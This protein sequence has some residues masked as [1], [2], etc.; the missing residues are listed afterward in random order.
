[1]KPRAGIPY[2]DG[3]IFLYIFILVVIIIVIGIALYTALIVQDLQDRIAGQME[4]ITINTPVVT[5]ENPTVCPGDILVWSL[6]LTYH[7]APMLME[8]I[9]NI[10]NVDQDVA[11]DYEQKASVP[12][13]KMGTDVSITNWLVPSLEPGRYRVI[14][15]TTNVHTVTAVDNK[16]L[17]YYV[18]FEVM[19]NC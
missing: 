12:I 3:K 11:I 16:L 6:E 7:D 5:A 13:V 17:Q 8:V 18:D 15:S 2:Y 9:R 1:M 4:L 10:A 19:E 14:V